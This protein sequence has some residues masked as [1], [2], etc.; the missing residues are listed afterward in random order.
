MNTELKHL[1]R[2]YGDYEVISEQASLR[3]LLTC[4]RSLA[5]L[6]ERKNMPRR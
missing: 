1:L 2:T 3:D 5:V 6:R 4:L